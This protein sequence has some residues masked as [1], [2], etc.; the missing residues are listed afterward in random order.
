MTELLILAVCL[1]ASALIITLGLVIMR[2]MK[3]K[4]GAVIKIIYCIFVCLLVFSGGTF[5]YLSIYY[6]ATG[7]AVAALSGSD[8]VKVTSS[9]DGYLFDGSGKDTLL[10]FY[11][12]AK[13]ESEAY[14]PLMNSI[15]ESGVD[16]FLLTMPFH[17]AILDI[18]AADRVIESHRYEH[19]IVSGHSLGGTAA[20]YW[21]SQS[22][23]ADA[24]VLLAPFPSSAL[25]DSMRLL[26][27]YGSEDGVLVK[28]QYEGSRQYF[29]ENSRELVIEGGNHAGF[30]DYGFQSGDKEALISAEKQQ[31]ITA[32]AVSQL[33]S[34]LQSSKSK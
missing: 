19:I 10:I 13:V 28:S 7:R 9:E 11:P 16:C 26:S 20:S 27:V 8:N 12:G 14:A 1:A 15:A 21:A 25:A 30:G 24:I 3:K 34:E 17:L 23:K 5:V 22:S 18:N 33:A 4:P 32:E 31:Q 2:R 6:K 29:P